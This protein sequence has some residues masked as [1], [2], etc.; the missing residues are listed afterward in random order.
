MSVIGHYIH[1][2][3]ANYQK[4]GI[5]EQGSKSGVSLD[6]AY[7]RQKADIKRRLANNKSKFTK[8]ELEEMSATITSFMQNMP[9]QAK[10][11]IVDDL[12]EHYSKVI[13]KG[14]DKNQ[15]L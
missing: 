11:I 15:D 2:N 8:A 9:Q 3:L 4:Y 13:E 10:D 14:I 6:A 1:Y 7:S 5:A 12:A